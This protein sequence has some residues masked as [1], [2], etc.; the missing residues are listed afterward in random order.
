MRQSGNHGG[1]IRAQLRGGHIARDSP[2]PGQGLEPFPQLAVAGHAAAQ[3]QGPGIQIDQS[4]LQVAQKGFDDSRLEAGQKV[5]EIRMIPGELLLFD[6]VEGGGFEPAEAEIKASVRHA[7]L[8]K[9]EARSIAPSRQAVDHRASGVA[10]V[11]E[12]GD[13]VQDLT[14]RIIP[15]F[16]EQP[17]LQWGFQEI[18]RTVAAADQK[19]KH[20]VFNLRI[21]NEHGMNMGLQVIDRD[22][23]QVPGIGQPL[24][25]REPDQ[26]GSDQTRSLGDPQAVDP[27]HLH[28]CALQSLGH[29][30]RDGTDVLAGSKLRHDP[31]V[32]RMDLILGEHD[33][34]ENGQVLRH[35]GGGGFVTGC[36]DP[37]DDVHGL[38]SGS[39]R[40]AAR[41]SAKG[42]RAIPRSV[43][44]AVM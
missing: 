23:G 4:T 24:G 10:Q 5:Q 33:I 11:E 44:T 2:L 37:Q 35:H 6:Q 9:H 31:A 14:S 38:V 7:G 28:A 32:R 3:N 22:Q 29:D 25:E 30:I 40:R 16:G 41:D 8:G 43:M 13:L 39:F 34:A 36:F 18:Q 27:P 1:I 42:G 17:V 21:F 19:G 15:R 20:G 12:F 26:E